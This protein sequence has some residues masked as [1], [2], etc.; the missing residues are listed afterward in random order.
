MSMSPN[1]HKSARL[2]LKNI[3]FLI[4]VI[5]FINEIHTKSYEDIRW[6]RNWTINEKIILENITSTSQLKPEMFRHIDEYYWMQSTYAY[7]LLFIKKDVRSPDWEKIQVYD[8][9][10]IGKYILGFGMDFLGNKMITTIDGL[11][12]IHSITTTSEYRPRLERLLKECSI[13]KNNRDNQIP[14]YIK[15]VELFVN[16]SKDEDII[17][18]GLQDLMNARKTTYFFTILSSIILI[19]IS[20]RLCNDINLALISGIIFYKNDIMTPFIQLAIVESIYIFFILLSLMTAIKLFDN[21]KEY[22]KNG[23]NRNQTLFYT[24]ILGISLSMAIGVKFITIYL[25]IAIFL[26]FLLQY[27]Y[28]LEQ[29]N[30]NLKKNNKN[31]QTIRL[32][33]VIL[34]L[35]ATIVL[36]LII[37]NPFLYENPI[38]NTYTMISHR[39]MMSKSQAASFGDPMRHI[40]NRIYFIIEYGLLLG[41]K[42]SLVSVL[43]LLVIFYGVY[44]LVKKTRLETRQVGAFTIILIWI[45]STYMILGSTIH[46]NWRRYF[47]PFAL[48]ICILIPLGL[49]NLIIEIIW[50]RE[51]INPRDPG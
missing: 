2:K 49:K 7:Y 45:L 13:L 31:K 21:I 51:R 30:K 46:V 39:L 14:E 32:T 29:E 36:S 20:H 42:S 38:Q 17:S 22:Q 1:L 23:K 28:N 33:F 47:I 3:V 5:V 16:Q 37:Q 18:L 12:R 19:M 50:I 11:N 43:L 27:K 9:P 24:I 26:T 15:H 8:Q 10:H 48:C 41:I 44:Y 6:D 25:P 40:Q 4:L 34:C 35:I